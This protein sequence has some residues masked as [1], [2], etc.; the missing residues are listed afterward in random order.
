MSS[1][2]TEIKGRY[3]QM[4]DSM[5]KIA[6]FIIANGKDAT[7]L[8][9]SEFARES[10]VSAASFSRFVR[11]LGFSGFTEFQLKLATSASVEATDQALVKDQLSYYGQE[12]GD[13]TKDICRTIFTKSTR[14][15]EETWGIVDTDVIEQ[16]AE[17]IDRAERIV[18]IGVGR[19]KITTKALVS[20][21]YRLGYHVAEYS[22]SHEIVNVTSIIQPEDL[23]IA[24]SNFGKSK[25]VVEGAQRA[26]QNGAVTVGITSVIDSPIARCADYM[27]LSAYDYSSDKMGDFFEPSV[28]NI[29]QLVLVDCIYMLVAVKHKEESLAKYKVFSEEIASEHVK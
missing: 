3:Q 23:L 8:K 1:M 13:S 9:A 25:A 11:M 29:A 12:V 5:K 4:N 14:V 18:V 7:H 10:G 17:L 24:V 19:S 21:L 20:R 27:I 28:E 22:D 26:A 6:D 16:V 15:I 2:I